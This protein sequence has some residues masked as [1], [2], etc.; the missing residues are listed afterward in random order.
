LR[1]NLRGGEM[2]SRIVRRGQL[3]RLTDLEG[4]ATPAALFY[5]AHQ[6]LE[7][8][9]APDTLKAQHT[10]KLTT[11]NVLF[12]DMGR[13]LMSIVG[14][15]AGWHDTVTGHMDAESSERKFGAGSYQTKR[16][17]FFRDTRSNFLIELGKHGLGKRDLTPNVNFFVKVTA[18]EQG[19]LDWRTTARAGQYVELRAEMDVLVVLSNTPHLLDPNERYAPK[20]L[21]LSLSIA[22]PVLPDDVCRLHCEQNAR[23]FQL[24]ESYHL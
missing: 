6:P 8:Y 14:D 16:N 13:V 24:T 18:D 11:G 9:N 3:L 7:R 12:S 1:E 21:E 4:G 20:A 19:K 10:A 23:G 5:N 17:D 22:G 2:W 15:S